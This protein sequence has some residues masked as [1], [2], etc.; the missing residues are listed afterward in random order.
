MKI[1]NYLDCIPYITQLT[2]AQASHVLESDD[3]R[4]QAEGRHLWVFGVL[5]GKANKKQRPAY[6]KVQ[7]GR[8]P[9]DAVCISFHPPEYPLTFLFPSIYS[10]TF[11]TIY[12]AQS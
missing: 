4:E 12:N 3:A 5:V 6:V 8:T 10:S 1:K 7:L 9:A 11:E 2:S